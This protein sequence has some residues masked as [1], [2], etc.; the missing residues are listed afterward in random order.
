ME[1]LYTL[2]FLLALGLVYL[3]VNLVP[4]LRAVALV[5]VVATATGLVLYTVAMLV[6]GVNNPNQAMLNVVLAIGLMMLPWATERVVDT[7]EAQ[8]PHRTTNPPPAA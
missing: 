3:V 8:R 6:R 5:V 1:A 2:L 7:W 4:V